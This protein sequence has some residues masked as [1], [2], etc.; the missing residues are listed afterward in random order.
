MKKQVNFLKKK[1]KGSGEG[2]KNH[3]ESALIQEAHLLGMLFVLLGAF[4]TLSFD[5]LI[6]LPLSAGN[7]TGKGCRNVSARSSFGVT[8][9]YVHGA[10][11][12]AFILGKRARARARGAKLEVLCNNFEK[13]PRQKLLKVYQAPPHSR[14]LSGN[15]STAI[16]ANW[17]KF[18]QGGCIKMRRLSVN[19]R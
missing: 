14:W 6:H 9:N 8:G 1:K 13:K 2:K 16:R 19:T 18:I 17:I 10:L 7:E 11:S 3:S 4:C 12:V 15:R 5:Q